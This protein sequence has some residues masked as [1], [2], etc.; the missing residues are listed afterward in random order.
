MS[1][2]K[3]D[4]STR[5]KGLQGEERACAH[6]ISRGYRILTRNYTRR[7][8]E[9]DIIAEK[10]GILVFVEVRSRGPGR[11]GYPLASIDRRKR[12]RIVRTAEDFMVRKELTM[13]SAR[14]DVIA[15]TGAEL[16]HIEGAFVKGE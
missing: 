16:E 13:R 14:F 2:K 7:I 4:N 12:R 6:L 10:D 15:I 5:E 1:S 9:I 3:A 11:Y 8:G